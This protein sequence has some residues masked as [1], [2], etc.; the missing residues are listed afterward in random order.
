MK[1]IDVPSKEQVSVENQAIFE[2][3][4][5][6]VGFVPN[7]YATY[8]LSDYALSKYITFSNGKTSLTGK[9]KEAV[10]LITSQVNGCNYCKAAHTAGGKQH[11]FTDDQLLE[12]RSGSAS[13]DPKLDAVVK[14]ARGIAEKKGQIDDHLLGN[15][16]EQG[17]DEGNLV[18]LIVAVGEKSITNMLHNVTHIPIDFPKAPPLH[19][20]SHA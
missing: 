6:K 8:A 12:I 17:F 11:G 3:L 16:F 2:Q 5:K 18:D 20:K 10:Y 9:Q 7:I 4:E 14:L 1:K 15:Y 19:E 13:F